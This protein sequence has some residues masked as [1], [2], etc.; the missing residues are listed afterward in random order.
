MR[1]TLES[2]KSCSLWVRTWALSLLAWP[3][4]YTMRKYF[5]LWM[6]WVLISAHLEL[7]ETQA[8]VW[9]IKP[10][11]CPW[12]QE[13]WD[14]HTELRI[15]HQSRLGPPLSRQETSNP[16]NH[17]IYKSGS[18]PPPP[19]WEA[20]APQYSPQSLL[21]SD[22]SSTSCHFPG[23]WLA[24]DPAKSPSREFPGSRFYTLGP[25]SLNGST[26]WQAAFSFL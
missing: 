1:R 19:S 20:P 5:T 6:N 11:M 15:L 3:L 16:F 26:R 17:R 23:G 22:S 12:R 4:L 25:H 7:R 2:N 13:S 9:F 14:K 18:G 8:R 21:F 24:A 10:H